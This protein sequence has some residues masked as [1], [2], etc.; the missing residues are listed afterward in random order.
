M[1]QMMGRG[2]STATVLFTDV[3]GSTEV[4][5]RLGEEEGDH[6]R[7]THDRIVARAVEANRGHV[8]KSLGD[9]LM[10]V[11]PSASDALAAAVA[12]QKALTRHNRSTA[13]RTPL[14]VRMGLSV[15]D[16]VF[17][18]NDCF[19]TPVV[20]A[21][22]LCTAARGAQILSS[23]LVRALAGTRGGHQFTSVGALRLKGLPAPV[24]S[25]EV[26]WDLEDG[27][28]VALPAGL[29]HPWSFPFVGREA[30]F[31]SL[32]RAWKETE[33]GER[34]VVLVSGEPGIGKTRLA[35]EL[36]RAAHQS[37]AVVLY[38]RCQ[39]ELGVPYHGFAEALRTYAA[40]C[41][42]EELRVQMG[43]LAG[44]LTRLVPTLPDRVAGLPEPLPAEPETERYRL[45]EAVAGLL[46]GISA[47]TPVLVVLD[48]L[49]WASAPD[50][51]LLRHLVGPAELGPVLLVATY[52]DTEIDDTHPLA[53]V[54]AFLGREPG[55]QRI[56][57]SGVDEAAVAQLLEVPGEFHEAARQ[58]LSRAVHAE[59]EGNPFF[60]TEVVRHI[61]ESGAALRPTGRLG[62]RQLLAALGVPE[63][64]RELVGR[65]LAR[66]PKAARDILAIAAVMGR[67]FDVSVLV[68]ASPGGIDAVL[69]A[70]E[71]AEEA[72][73]VAA[74]GGRLDRYTFAHSLV[75]A[76]LY[77]GLPVSRRARVHRR[78]AEALALRARDDDLPDLA[79][80][81]H[82]AGPA[83]D[84][85]L[86]V[87]YACRAARQADTRLAHEQAAI[88][89]GLA[90]EALS[91]MAAMEGRRAAMLLAR[92]EAWRRAGEIELAREDFLAAS[93]LARE[94]PDAEAMA[95][96]ALGLGDV[97]AVWG[98][99]EVLIGLLRA[100]LER[101]GSERRALR[102]CLLARLGQA[103]YYSEPDQRLDL[104]RQ[105]VEEA[106][107]AGDPA[108][109]AVVLR[110][111]HVALSGPDGL[112]ERKAVADDIVRLATE[113]G[114]PELAL[115]GHGW[116]FVDLLELGDRDGADRDLAAHAELAR[117]LR[118][119]LHLR[120]AA[121]WRATVA[122]LE[123]RFDDA[124][125]DI[126]EA[127]LLGQQAND[128][129]V[130]GAWWVQ[131]GWLFLDAERSRELPAV[132]EVTRRFV[133][134]Y[135][136]V[137]A[138]VAARALLAAG[139]GEHE[140]ARDDVEELVR[141]RLDD[142]PKDAAW[143][144]CLVLLAA[145]SSELRDDEH[146]PALYD[147][148]LP[149]AHR[150]VVP[151]RAWACRG[152][153]CHYLGGL[154]VLMGRRDDAA[155]HFE[156]ACELHACL[157]ARPLLARSQYA[158]AGMLLDRGG[159]GD[160]ATAVDLAARSLRSAQALGLG[161]LALDVRPLL[162]EA[163][164]AKRL[165]AD[166]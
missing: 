61:V 125:A 27:G 136:A 119:P 138:W 8:V 159:T 128:P 129:S 124:E 74:V 71:R 109:L 24:P 132:L 148:L 3:V 72:R 114:D 7:R 75:R 137:P 2:S 22:R 63:G 70:L 65:R 162:E 36:A 107:R 154:A 84:P 121:I 17:E 64:V 51:A 23:D 115:H 117:S 116:R 49:H 67:E 1:A 127:R 18:G 42:D 78:V 156:H 100:A 141:G 130:E 39:E 92:G 73:L 43:P 104:S 120:D 90:L 102:A 106:R 140:A 83:G 89:Y 53:P 41:S 147:L 95:R 103:L 52:R 28:G 25:L 164:E 66:L 161:K 68:A 19:G 62:A 151:D 33:A 87:E 55:V 26:E 113:A 46:A 69:Q 112:S 21:A 76:A 153:V 146:A 94:A 40:A 12:A 29:D 93:H 165:S 99:D 101:L 135:P 123:G 59:T 57:L 122:T 134:T 143:L 142:M 34:R 54:L 97:S 77:D 14:D 56:R 163:T 13:A 81:F 111:H 105:A 6:L 82:A 108:A 131:R 139:L 110:A 16:V 96:A 47:V 166:G 79:R 145:T 48:D 31:D 35:A 155:R 144:I 50:V 85:T 157:R 32:R 149:Y 88:C 80:H 5:A 160:A 20:E 11:F 37:G 4:R 126:A 150:V 60:V 158:Y 10:A 152:A 98:F 44:E 91:W 133:E 58:S 9:G 38:G 86:A 30:E 15:G 118:Q 45:F